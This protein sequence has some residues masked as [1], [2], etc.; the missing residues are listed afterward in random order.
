MR[1]MGSGRF[2]IAAILGAEV[3]LVTAAGLLL[4]LLLTFAALA[5][6]Q[7]RLTG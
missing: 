3:G 4:A 5:A 2:T 7:G 6:V 1:R